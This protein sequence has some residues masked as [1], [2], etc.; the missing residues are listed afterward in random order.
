MDRRIWRLRDEVATALAGLVREVQWDGDEEAIAMWAELGLP[1]EPAG[2]A[3]DL[4]GAA[5]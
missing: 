2:M 1:S 4:A 3:G 5:R